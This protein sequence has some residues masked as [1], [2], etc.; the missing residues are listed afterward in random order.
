MP[1]PRQPKPIPRPHSPIPEGDLPL[2]VDDRNPPAA[3]DELRT[4]KAT[5]LVEFNRIAECEFVSL[6]LRLLAASGGGMRVRQVCIEAAARLDISI[7]TS[8]RYLLKHSASISEFNIEKG[9][10]QARPSPAPKK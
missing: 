2:D 5:D 3:E 1:T 10:V 8:K 4:L 7:E 9:W 6:T